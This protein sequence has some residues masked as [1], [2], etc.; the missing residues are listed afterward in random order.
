MADDTPL[1]LRARA[2]AAASRTRETTSSGT[3]MAQ[4]VQEAASALQR[5][6]GQL[7]NNVSDTSRGAIRMDVDGLLFEFDAAETRLVFLRECRNCGARLTYTVRSI[8]DLGLALADPCPHPGRSGEWQA[9][10][11]EA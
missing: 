5:A 7:P 3:E 6:I 4:R 9:V 2:L 1:S 8:E 11:R 10:D